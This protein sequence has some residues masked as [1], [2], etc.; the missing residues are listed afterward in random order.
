MS[1]GRPR[2]RKLAI[3]C[4]ALVVLF[5]ATE[6]G[7]RFFGYNRQQR[8]TEYCLFCEFGLQTC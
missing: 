1:K 5:G 6:V 8:F 7:L 3:S 2:W 4:G